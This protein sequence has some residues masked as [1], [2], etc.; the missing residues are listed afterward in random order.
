VLNAVSGGLGVRATEQGF[1]VRFSRLEDVRQGMRKDGAFSP[2]ALQ[3]NKYPRPG[4]SGKVGKA[5]QMVRH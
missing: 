1:S 5:P 2:Q 4:R 3:G